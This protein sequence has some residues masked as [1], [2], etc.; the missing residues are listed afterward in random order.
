V[1]NLKT[2]KKIQAAFVEHSIAN[3][4]R[5]KLQHELF[6]WVEKQGVDI[7][8]VRFMDSIGVRISEDEFDSFE[9][10]VAELKRYKNGEE[11]GYG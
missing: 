1:D 7:T 3:N 4:K 8:E 11:V 5:L 6:N 10:F 9:E 2:T